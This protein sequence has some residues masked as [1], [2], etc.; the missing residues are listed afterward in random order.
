MKHFGKGGIYVSLDAGISI[1]LKSEFAFGI[2]DCLVS[3]GMEIYNSCGQIYLIT[4]NDYDWDYLEI[5]YDMLRD[6]IEYRQSCGYPIGIGLL[7]D[8][9]RITNM[10]F[11]GSGLV[12]FN[13]DINRKTFIVDN[14]IYTDV[15]WYIENIIVLLSNKF[16]ILSLKFWE[17]R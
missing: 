16:E 8:N 2:V 6:Y 13:C 4:S 3:Q 1:E 17:I 12:T 9:V 7:K 11:D 14:K 5:D 10:L 15:N